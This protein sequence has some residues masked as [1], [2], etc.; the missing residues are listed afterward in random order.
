MVLVVPAALVGGGDDPV[1]RRAEGRSRRALVI[2][3][4]TVACT[5]WSVCSLR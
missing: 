5:V 1:S 4:S 3:V 2:D